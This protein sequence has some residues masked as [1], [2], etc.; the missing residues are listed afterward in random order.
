MHLSGLAHQLHPAV[1]AGQVCPEALHD[2]SGPWTPA[3]QLVHQVLEGPGAPWL[4]SCL[5]VLEILEGPRVQALQGPQHHRV[6]QDG[7][8][9]PWVQ[10]PP[11]VPSLH[12]LPSPQQFQALQPDQ[13]IP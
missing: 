8:S 10:V 11:G 2:P 5:A 7:P 3:P 4:L 9:T 13:Q 1:L 12:G 6:F